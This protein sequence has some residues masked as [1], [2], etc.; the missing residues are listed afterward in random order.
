[1]NHYSDYSPYDFWSSKDERKLGSDI[2]QANFISK[3]T[4]RPRKKN[5]K[6]GGNKK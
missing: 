5:K 1:M 4:E 2:K 3:I 6:R